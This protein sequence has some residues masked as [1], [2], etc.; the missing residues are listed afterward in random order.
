MKESH[1]TCNNG[2]Y[3]VFSN[4]GYLLVAILRFL[5]GHEYNQRVCAIKL[6]IFWQN[7]LFLCTEVHYCTVCKY[8]VD[9]HSFSVTNSSNFI[10][11]LIYEICS[12]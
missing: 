12:L 4:F 7:L 11:I 3:S 1:S 6:D 10:F 8:I 5:V 2:R 9:S